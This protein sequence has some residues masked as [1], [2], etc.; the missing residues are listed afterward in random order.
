MLA[1]DKIQR[2]G[3]QYPDNRRIITRPCCWKLRCPMINM[4]GRCWRESAIA[5][6]D[7]AR[8]IAR[9]P[10]TW[11]SAS[12]N[13]YCNLMQ[14]CAT[15]SMAALCWSNHSTALLPHTLER[16]TGCDGVCRKGF[17]ATEVA[18]WRSAVQVVYYAQNWAGK[19]GH[20]CLGPD[21]VD[22]QSPAKLVRRHRACISRR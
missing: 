4:L 22:W 6:R 18:N 14:R 10:V 20:L 5:E 8:P 17:P 3:S 21:V 19:A 7:E 9:K 2:S 12:R 11:L 1:N 16:L 15:R 13:L